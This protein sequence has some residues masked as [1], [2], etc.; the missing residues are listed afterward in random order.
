[1][2]AIECFATFKK[3]ML[4]QT[5]TD[6]TGSSILPGSF[7]VECMRFNKE[8]YPEYSTQGVKILFCTSLQ[9]C[10]VS[11]NK[12][13]SIIEI[14][15]LESEEILAEIEFDHNI[16]GITWDASG[17][18]VV[19]CDSGGYLHFATSE[20]LLLFTKKIVTGELSK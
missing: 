5:F 15:A 11:I 12:T 6:I 1:M 17:C 7:T 14:A 8:A 20:G 18:F 9:F 10:A 13:L 3:K 19:L 16:V 2:D 4:E